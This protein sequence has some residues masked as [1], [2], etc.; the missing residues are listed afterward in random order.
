VSDENTKR[1]KREKKMKKKMKKAVPSPVC[2]F[3]CPKGARAVIVKV[4]VKI[5]GKAREQQQ[6][7]TTASI[8][9]TAR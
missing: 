6:G 5:K 1:V 3:P 7:N 8:K 9:K 2:L 4:K